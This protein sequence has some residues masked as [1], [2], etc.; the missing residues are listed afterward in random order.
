MCE[1][2]TRSW[3]EF[4]DRAGRL[5]SALA[6]RVWPWVEARAL[7]LNCNEYTE[8]HFG[9]F[10]L[11]ACPINVNY[12]Y[13]A[14]ELVY[15][16]ENPTPRPCC[17]TAVLLI[18]SRRSA[19]LA[20]VS[21]IF[22]GRWFRGALLAGAGFEAALAEQL[23]HPG[24]APADD[25]YVLGGTRRAKGV[26][27]ES[28]PSTRRWRLP[29][30][31]FGALSP[32]SGDLVAKAQALHG[33]GAA[34]VSLPACPQMHGTGMWIGTIIPLLC[35]G[36]VVTQRTAHFD[37]DVLFQTVAAE[38]VTDL[39]IVG[40]AFARPMVAALDAADAAG[41]PYDLSRLALISSSGVMWSQEVKAGLHRHKDFMLYDAM[42]STDGSMGSSVATRDAPATT[43]LCP[44]GNVKVFTED[45]REVTP[46]DE[47]GLVAGVP[48]AT[49]RIRR[50]PPTF[51][52]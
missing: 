47:V 35:G 36:C 27:Y 45:D 13:Q 31:L 24:A 10:K 1:G 52:P 3:A 9:A 12:R 8:A 38:G 33:A 20:G 46:E 14:D 25:I 37:P 49:I 5:A 43:A 34:P 16:L 44:R 39:T 17:S 50:S 29:G 11:G 4:G 2:Q 26:M 41:S 22:V 28:R 6:P 32:E 30:L 7:P 15:L 51:G 42:G 23:R 19:S 21:C 40:D 48:S 18:G